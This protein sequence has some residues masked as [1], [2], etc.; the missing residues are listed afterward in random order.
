MVSDTDIELALD[1]K[2]G[3]L[4]LHCVYN[5]VYAEHLFPFENLE[6]W[7]TRGRDAPPPPKQNKTQQ[8]VGH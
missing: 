3:Q 1:D 2:S 4:C 8:N 5:V 6:F 7:Y